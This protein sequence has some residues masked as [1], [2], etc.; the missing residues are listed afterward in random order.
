VQ[1]QVCHSLSLAEVRR[2]D[3]TFAAGARG[4]S[5]PL[6]VSASGSDSEDAELWGFDEMSGSFETLAGDG[7]GIVGFFG[8]DRVVA[9]RF[10]VL[11]P[12]CVAG[13]LD[14]STSVRAPLGTG[15]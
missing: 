7:D 6:R 12:G 9:G 11:G 15:H 10:R 1:S 3:E 14:R 13:G 5:K 4:V 8:G 2:S